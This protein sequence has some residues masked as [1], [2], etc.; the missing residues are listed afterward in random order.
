MLGMKREQLSKFKTYTL[1]EPTRPPS[2]P[3]LLEALVAR[4]EAE[5]GLTRIPKDGDLTLLQP[6]AWI[7]VLR[8]GAH[9]TAQP[10][11]DRAFAERRHVHPLDGGL[12]PLTGVDA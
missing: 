4:V 9:L 10:T 5:Q 12:S 2:R 1:A 6:A 7:L 8:L 3:V 11:E